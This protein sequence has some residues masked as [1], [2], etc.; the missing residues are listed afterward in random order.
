MPHSDRYA[1]DA[2][3]EVLDMGD[4]EPLAAFLEQL[5]RG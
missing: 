5:A 1:L 3:D 4:A 2:A